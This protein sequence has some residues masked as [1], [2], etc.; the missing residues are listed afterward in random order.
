MYS[1]VLGKPNNIAIPAMFMNNDTIHDIRKRLSLLTEQSIIKY[2]LD[3][4]K[5]LN[6]EIVKGKY[7]RLLI[8]NEHCSSRLTSLEEIQTLF[9]FL[10]KLSD[11]I[12]VIVYLRPQSD[13]VISSYSTAIKA[14]G[15]KKFKFSR[16]N[17]EKLNYLE[18]YNKWASVFGE[19]NLIV[20]TFDA[21]LVGGDI[22]EDFVQTAN[23]PLIE[24]KRPSNM[25]NTSLDAD[26]VE[27]L[28]RIN[29]Y[30]PLFI[31]NEP[32]PLR[33]EIVKQLEKLEPNQK[34]EIS[35]SL[36][37]EFDK[38]FTDSNRQLARIIFDDDTLFHKK[39][40][41]SKKESKKDSKRNIYEIFSHLY[42][43]QQKDKI[44]AKC[45]I[46]ELNNVITRERNINKSRVEDLKNK[47]ELERNKNL[48]LRAEVQ[49]QHK[50]Y[51][52]VKVILDS[53]PSILLKDPGYLFLNALLNSKTNN[54]EKAI[55]LINLG[56]KIDG[57]NQRLLNLKNKLT[58]S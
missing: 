9:Q 13:L 16:K 54:K 39:V 2:K 38:H 35:D 42:I 6:E 15:T 20:R 3:I 17:I 7:E 41:N 11:K 50:N 49:L 26:S 18:F 8:S 36:K 52:N 19:E 10:K 28:R 22:I 48:L 46:E 31:G 53:A 21:R 4:E 29:K 12:S 51:D 33:G 58:L 34:I 14:G 5:K 56:L 32:N 24:D 25:K 37:G 23:I 57:N 45:I 44:E 55:E 43:N 47:I 40:V 27:F 1:E 30:I